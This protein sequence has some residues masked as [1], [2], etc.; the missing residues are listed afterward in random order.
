MQLNEVSGKGRICKGKS[1]NKEVAE[2]EKAM[3]RGLKKRRRHTEEGPQEYEKQDIE[4]RRVMGK[5]SK[6]RQERMKEKVGS[7]LYANYLPENVEN[8]KHRSFSGFCPFWSVLSR[9]V[10]FFASSISLHLTVFLLRGHFKQ[11]CIYS[12]KKM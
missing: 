1:W 2:V 6:I 11:I 3:W 5:K 12:L 7:S 8:I 9:D 10:L 4:C